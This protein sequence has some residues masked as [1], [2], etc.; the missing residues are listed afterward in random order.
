M[1]STYKEPNKGAELVHV[2]VLM[3]HHKRAP[4]FLLPNEREINVD[5]GWDCS[6]VKQFNYNGGGTHLYHSVNTP[7]GHPFASKFWAGTCEEGQL[8]PGGFHD[9]KIHGKDLWEVYH[10]RLGFLTSVEPSE[11]G[12]R[13][14]YVDRTKQVASG[15][16]AGM[17]PSI[18][19]RGWAAHAQP[20][21]IDSLIPSYECPRADALL[22]EAYAAPFWQDVLKKNSA[23]KD[24]LDNVLGTKNSTS[25][26]W[27]STFMAYQDVLTARTCNDHPLPCNAAG[28]CISE[29]DAAEIFAL[30]N[31]E[32]DY[33][34]HLAKTASEYTQL[35]FG[36][37]FSELADALE[38]PKHRLALYVAH[39]ISI[40]R[41]AAGLK[42]FPLRWPRLGSE[43]AIEIWKVKNNR[44]FVRVLYD[45][46]LVDSLQWIPLGN[47]I[48]LL[49][50]E[51]PEHIFEKC[52]SASD[53]AEG[54]NHTSAFL[55]MQ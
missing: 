55:T 44:R 12:V 11:I 9:S 50:H 45:G 52:M 10:T 31:F 27:T 32:A 13:T 43:I 40:V 8:T 53:E 23:L 49:R 2:S 54:C 14:T 29:E 38:S 3:R 34:W 21:K 16:L 36:V 28:D 25:A 1:A 6:G 15:V 18:I 35:T 5:L 42:I 41:L 4:A 33:L 24:R 26:V 20:Q 39:D 30:G 22:A 48:R 37:L 19:Q 51:V 46:E 47:F 17:D 7:P